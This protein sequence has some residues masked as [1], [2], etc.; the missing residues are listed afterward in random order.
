MWCG[1]YRKSK[2]ESSTK[3]LLAQFHDV[4]SVGAPAS[5]HIQSVLHVSSKGVGNRRQTYISGHQRLGGRVSFMDENHG[6]P[7]HGVLSW[8]WFLG[9]LKPTLCGVKSKNLSQR[10]SCPGGSSVQVLIGISTNSSWRYNI[11]FLA[12][13]CSSSYKNPE[14]NNLPVNILTKCS[15][16]VKKIVRPNCVQLGPSL[17]MRARLLSYHLVKNHYSQ[18]QSEEWHKLPQNGTWEITTK[19]RCGMNVDDWYRDSWLQKG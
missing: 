15:K 16:T 2:D 8:V 1:S 17:R 5:L 6:E 19:L 9:F 4:L 10:G 11:V 7:S 3:R 12:R 18:V 14:Q 13:P